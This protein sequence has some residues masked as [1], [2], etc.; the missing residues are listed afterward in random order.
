VESHKKG[1]KRQQNQNMGELNSRCRYQRRSLFIRIYRPAIY[2]GLSG[3]SG[4]QK[5]ILAEY[6]NQENL[7]GKNSFADEEKGLDFLL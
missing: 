2:Q 4:G 1:S 3:K 6:T 5:S 7:A